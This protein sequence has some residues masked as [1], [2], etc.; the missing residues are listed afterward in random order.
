MDS[1]LSISIVLVVFIVP[2]NSAESCIC[3]ICAKEETF[4]NLF[5]F[6]LSCHLHLQTIFLSF[7]RALKNGTYSKKAEVLIKIVCFALFSNKE[8]Y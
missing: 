7:I 6:L 4:M 8:L 2:I 3:N 1:I 5:K